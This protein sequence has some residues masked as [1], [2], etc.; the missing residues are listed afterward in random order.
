MENSALEEIREVKASLSRLLVSSDLSYAFISG[1][2][3]EEGSLRELKSNG[4]YYP[5]IDIIVWGNEAL[6]IPVLKN[7]GF[8]NQNGT[9]YS[10]DMKGVS[11]DIYFNWIS[12]DIIKIFTPRIETVE[13][14]QISERDYIIYQLIEPILKFGQHHER[15]KHRLNLYKTNIPVEYKLAKRRVSSY[16]FPFFYLID[17]AI[18]KEKLSRFEHRLLKF[19]FIT[20]PRNIGTYI[21][22][23]YKNS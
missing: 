14:N 13:N 5:D 20:K 16:C 15:H 2:Y 11:V 22:H 7:L 10:I 8:K 6:I 12:Y 4:Q 1:T 23:K 3:E 18:A 19:I 21:K 9:S 17:K